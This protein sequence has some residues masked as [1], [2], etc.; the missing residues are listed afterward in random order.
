MC[1]SKSSFFSQVVLWK[2][3]EYST[4]QNQHHVLGYIYKTRVEVNWCRGLSNQKQRRVMRTN[5]SIF[6]L[7]GQCYSTHQRLFWIDWMQNWE[8][9]Q[10]GFERL[11]SS[12]F[13]LKF[14]LNWS[15]T[16]WFGIPMTSRSLRP[17]VRSN[18]HF[19]EPHTC[20]LVSP[21]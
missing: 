13:F 6:W 5:N 17:I 11:F 8:N 10:Q 21:C 18:T 3:K 20:C 1:V 14:V 12:D 15:D 4:W 9:P 19:R 7:E 16:S 2:L